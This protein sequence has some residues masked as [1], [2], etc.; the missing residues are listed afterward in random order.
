MKI[1]G[2]INA[3]LDQ[4][5]H[6]VWSV[7]PETMVYDA[8]HTMA[9][10]NIGAL[11]V[12]QAGRLAGMISE[13]DYTRKIILQGK[14]SKQTPVLDIMS[15]TLVTVSPESTVMEGM[16]LMTEYRVR[17][18]PVL[19]HGKLV[20]LVSIGNLVNWVISAQHA[21]IGQLEDY[22]RGTYPG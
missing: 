10:K 15:T 7:T 12:L 2:S 8:I 4:K 14:S 17:H 16:R 19:D 21:A 6:E 20:G 5:G 3:V 18:L 9:E 11:P 1:D 22:I 13:R